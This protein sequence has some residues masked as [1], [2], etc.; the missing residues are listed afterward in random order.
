MYV[1]FQNL[2]CNNKKKKF[3]KYRTFYF[4]MLKFPRVFMY[5][6][7][8]M[9]MQSRVCGHVVLQFVIFAYVTCKTLTLIFARSNTFR[10]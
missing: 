5:H 3:N 9:K 1:F 6:I 4:Y 10:V 2:L 8:L 7:I